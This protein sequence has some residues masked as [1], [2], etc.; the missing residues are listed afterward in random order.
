MTQRFRLALVAFVAL[1]GTVAVVWLFKRGSE[2]GPGLGLETAG[3]APSGGAGGSALEGPGATA[4][5]STTLSGAGGGGTPAAA[6]GG[7]LPLG[8]RLP[9]GVD[10]SDPAQRRAFL[11]ELLRKVPVPW[12]DVAQVVAITPEPLDPVAREALLTALRSGDRNG[13][14]KALS[15]AH[16]GT[17][18]PDLLAILDDASA[19]TG[20][21]RIVL[22]VLGQMPIE[23]RDGVAKALEARLK[24]DLSADYEVLDALARRG[25]KEAVRA[26]V[27]YVERSP[28]AA[29]A[30]QAL[31]GRL[32]LKGDREAAAIV[33][34]ALGRRQ[35]PGALETLLRVAAEPGAAGL[36]PALIRLDA[37][38]VP[39][40]TR[41][42]VYDAL[43]Q[44]G[45]ADAMEHLLTVS[46]QPGLYG[47][48]ALLALANVRSAND[49]A[50]AA[51]VAEL[52]R[53][54]LNPRP[55]MAKSALLEA[56]GRLQVQ[57][58]LPLVVGSLR[59]SSDQVRNSA[60]RAIG[61]MRTV[62]RPHVA[63][64]AAL[65]ASGSVATRTAVVMALGN[66]GGTEAAQRLEEF[67]K[68]EALDSSLRRTIGY[69]ADQARGGPVEGGTK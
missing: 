11:L 35:S 62:A 67:L 27:E 8:L 4:D 18:V 64:L 58:A 48:K 38:D 41:A 7:A 54:A 66:I 15:V 44:I 9:K 30:W 47:E 21:R 50:R 3:R 57:Q 2:A 20:A 65:F 55:E 63:D 14:Y 28:D 59:D 17:L 25:G 42:L 5:P 22:L 34:E 13:A 31:S 26:V 19:A 60:I 51:L 29:K 43:A 33:A 12:D 24:G 37:D 10:L 40:A 32:D 53:A 23:D 52:E 56:V 61:L 68:D 36:A 46:R 16:D 49:E 45:S 69:A 39:E 1:V 6:T